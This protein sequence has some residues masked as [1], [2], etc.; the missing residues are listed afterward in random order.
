MIAR[1]VGRDERRID[2][3]VIQRDG[4]LGA[5]G[6]RRGHT[7][8]VALRPTESS[9]GPGTRA[10]SSVGAPV[11]GSTEP[12]GTRRQCPSRAAIYGNAV[13]QSARRKETGRREC[14]NSPRDRERRIE[15]PPR[16]SPRRSR[17]SAHPPTRQS[18]PSPGGQ[19]SAP[20]NTLKGEGSMVLRKTVHR[21]RR[22]SEALAGGEPSIPL[23]STSKKRSRHSRPVGVK[24]SRA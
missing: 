18:P 16:S 11:S 12:Q 9:C 22:W 19:C 21:R 8:A 14:S 13:N 1:S 17:P 7:G 4:W 10:P 23:P 24:S 2:P 20:K 5:G 15:G 6:D 3:G